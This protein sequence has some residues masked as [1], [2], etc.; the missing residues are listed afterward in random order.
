MSYHIQCWIVS[1]FASSFKSLSILRWSRMNFLKA[2]CRTSTLPPHAAACHLRDDA[3]VFDGAGG[4]WQWLRLG[5]RGRKL[6]LVVLTSPNYES[7]NLVNGLRFWKSLIDVCIYLCVCP[8]FSSHDYLWNDT[9][10]RTH[11][12]SIKSR[13]TVTYFHIRNSKMAGSPFFIGKIS[14]ISRNTPS[15]ESLPCFNH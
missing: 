6:R 12:S 9:P 7:A 14:G 4:A 3:N 13:I 1:M 10:W 11:D 15:S 2:M 8:V 5:F